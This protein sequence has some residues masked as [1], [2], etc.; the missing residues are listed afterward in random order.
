MD[1]I[2]II[3]KPYPDEL[4]FSYLMRI[5]ELNFFDQKFFYEE[6]LC[7][8]SK[9]YKEISGR[10]NITYDMRPFMKLANVKDY[11]DFYL[12]RSTYL[13]LSPFL[14]LEDKANVV[15]R[16]L[17][18]YSLNPSIWPKRKPA[19]LDL[20]I[21][22]ECVNEDI[23]EYGSFYHH[24]S[25]QLRGV[26]VCYKHKTPLKTLSDGLGREFDL[27]AYKYMADTKISE[28]DHLYASLMHTLLNPTSENRKYLLDRLGEDENLDL[29]I[30]K[31][32]NKI[33]KSFYSHQLEEELKIKNNIMYYLKNG[34]YKNN[35]VE[36]YKDLDVVKVYQDNIYLC[37]CKLCGNKFITTKFAL[38]IGYGCSCKREFKTCEGIVKDIFDKTNSDNRFTLLYAS[39]TNII[40]ELLLYD[41]AARNVLFIHPFMFFSKRFDR[42]S[43]IPTKL[44]PGPYRLANFHDL[45]KLSYRIFI[46]DD[47]LVLECKNCNNRRLQ[48]HNN[49]Y[50]TP[51]DFHKEGEKV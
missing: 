35:S 9:Y 18:D 34:Y 32:T 28:L 10:Y 14:R 1:S 3:V 4:L 8:C 26:D 12:S 38:D 51:C 24:R 15:G 23:N 7:F 6:V 20:K 41:M 39:G 17:S 27:E 36:K 48:G 25:H 44:E 40:S 50:L 11:L 19:F 22:P 43:N 33:K 5:K 2:P 21:C 31:A 45:D 16:V 46:E 29:F 47:E 37:K 30:R 49:T 42:V 13:A